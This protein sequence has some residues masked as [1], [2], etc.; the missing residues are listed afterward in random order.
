MVACLQSLLPKHNDIKSATSYGED[1]LNGPW[2]AALTGIR[3]SNHPT[4][5]GCFCFRKGRIPTLSLNIWFEKIVPEDLSFKA[6]RFSVSDLQGNYSG[7]L[8]QSKLS[9][10]GRTHC[11]RLFLLS[12]TAMAS[13]LE[14]CLSFT[15]GHGAL[16]EV[17]AG[18][19]G[20]YKMPLLCSCHPR[21]LGRG[22]VL[23]GLHLFASVSFRC[24]GAPRTVCTQ[25]RLRPAFASTRDSY[26]TLLIP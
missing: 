19:K 26:I 23:R 2:R 1:F 10:E 15:R 16:A 13:T 20:P 22:S 5:N 21:P 14:F 4:R 9:D 25:R 11:S 3:R 12:G 7:Q 18:L 6:L 8:E 17:H 24:S